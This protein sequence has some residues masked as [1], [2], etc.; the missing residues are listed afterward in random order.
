MHLI[1]G[2]VVVE[3][4]E[5]E[6][7]EAGEQRMKARYCSQEWVHLWRDPNYLDLHIQVHP[8]RCCQLSPSR[9]DFAQY[10]YHDCRHQLWIASVHD[11]HEADV[12]GGDSLIIHILTFEVIGRVGLL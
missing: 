6:E 12:A 4:E 3:E 1:Q 11:S 5:E 8:M 10:H 2:V 9:M 7:G